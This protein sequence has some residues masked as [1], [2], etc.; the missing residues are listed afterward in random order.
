MIASTLAGDGGRV[1]SA[2]GK[3]QGQRIAMELPALK[4]WMLAVVAGLGAIA[5]PAVA[6]ENVRAKYAEYAQACRTEPG[7][8]GSNPCSHALWYYGGRISLEDLEE[9]LELL[10]ENCRPEGRIAGCS[11]LHSFYA[12]NERLFADGTRRTWPRQPDLALKAAQTGCRATL[13]GV[14]N[15]GSLGL[16]HEA[17][18]DFAAA[19]RA[20]AM[21]CEAGMRARTGEYYGQGRVCYWAAKNARDNLQDHANARRWF[22]YVC[23]AERDPFACKFLGLMYAQGEGGEADPVSALG[24][25]ARACNMVDDIRTG[26]GQSCFLL[27]QSLVTLRDKV[28]PQGAGYRYRAATTGDPAPEARPRDNLVVASRAFLRAC[29]DGRTEG[30]KAHAELLGAWSTGGH[31]RTPLRCRLMD[32]AGQMAPES[33]CQRFDFYLSSP[34]GTD[35]QSP[36]SVFVWPDGDRTILVGDDM[37]PTLNGAAAEWSVSGHWEC[38]RSAVTGRSFCLAS[39]SL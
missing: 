7:T 13:E 19:G 11:T 18:G 15:C 29:M 35:D 36:A 25:Y 10:W 34:A 38:A 39:P 20:Y 14:G 37:A 22:D 33:V 1:R 4:A 21:G 6:E 5:G 27:G 24:L 16:H 9:P 30:C 8:D 3:G 12:G 31:P 26:D 17:A 28:V 2:L 32:A 23:E